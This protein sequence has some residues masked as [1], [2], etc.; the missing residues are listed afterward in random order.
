MISTFWIMQT[1]LLPGCTPSRKWS[2]L[3]PPTTCPQLE[4]KSQ[5][6]RF[7]QGV[8]KWYI[9]DSPLQTSPIISLTF[10][11]VGNW[12]NLK[13]ISTLSYFTSLLLQMTKKIRNENTAAGDRD[14]GSL[15]VAVRSS[16][17]SEFYLKINLFFFSHQSQ[18]QEYFA[19][20]FTKQDLQRS[21]SYQAEKMYLLSRCVLCTC[22]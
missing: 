4:H 15:T 6:Q 14:C 3:F 18:R 7:P 9:H 2:I 21:W 5:G 17:Q 13:G 19:S 11:R 12:Y 10:L 22:M 1:R 16:S 8:H 20:L